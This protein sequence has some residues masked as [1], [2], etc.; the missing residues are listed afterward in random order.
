MTTLNM[1]TLNMTTPTAWSA[2]LMDTAEQILNTHVG[3]VAQ[4]KTPQAADA[5]VC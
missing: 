2:T 4:E 3:S 5:A 1:T